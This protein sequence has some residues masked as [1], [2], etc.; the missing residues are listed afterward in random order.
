[1]SRLSALAA[2]AVLMLGPAAAA[3]PSVPAPTF[4]DPTALVTW[5]ITHSGHG[6]EARDDAATATVFSPGLR[7]AIRTSFARSRQRKEPPCGA[8]GDIILDSQEP[9]TPENL[10]VSAQTT[11]PDR[12]TVAATFDIVGYHRTPKFMTVLLDGT[13][14]VENIISADGLSL[15][16]SLDCRR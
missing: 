3:A 15:R 1:M 9:G 11:A 16:R 12:Q 13:W 4:N 2:C 6:F 14:K 7:A 8:D 5:L 10:R